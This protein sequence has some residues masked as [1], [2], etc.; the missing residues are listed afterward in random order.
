MLSYN[1]RKSEPFNDM[2]GKC[3][4]VQTASGYIVHSRFY[5]K[6]ITCLEKGLQLFKSY[7]RDHHNHV[8]DQYWK[9]LQPSSNWYYSLKRV[10]KQRSGFSNLQNCYVNYDV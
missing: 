2:F 7:P 8:N 10:G 1:L 5:D 9:I 3:L 6:L 4:E